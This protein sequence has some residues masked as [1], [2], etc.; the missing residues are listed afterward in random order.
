M[1]NRIISQAPLPHPLQGIMMDIDG[2]VW[3]GDTLLI[4]PDTINKLLLYIGAKFLFLSNNSTKTNEQY[5]QR[6]RSFGIHIEK[7]H[8]LTSSDATAQYLPGIIPPPGPIFVVGEEGLVLSLISA[9]YHISEDNPKA[10]VAGLDRYINFKKLETATLAIRKGAIFIGTNPDRTFPIPEGLA[11]GAG[12]IL[13][14]IEAATDVVPLII[15]KPNKTTS[16][17]ESSN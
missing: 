15:G 17:Y 4:N 11:P 9:G 13:A 12:A 2:V 1:Q 3:R 10:V 16:C 7:Q 8:V 14:S 5:L 6:F